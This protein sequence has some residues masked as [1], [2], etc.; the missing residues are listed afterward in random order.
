MR[1]NAMKL[2]ILEAS[3]REITEATGIDRVSIIHLFKRCLLIHPDGRI[4]GFRALLL[5]TRIMP[6]RRSAPAAVTTATSKSGACA[7]GNLLSR[8][9]DIERELQDYV[10]KRARRKHGNLSGNRYVHESRIPIKSLHKRFI[11]ACRKHNLETMGQY[12]ST[13]KKLAYE[14]L[15]QYVH[16][17]MEQNWDGGAKARLGVDAAKVL[18]TGDGTD[19]PVFMPFER[20]ECDAHLIDAIFCI[21]IPSLSDELIPQIVQRL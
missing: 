2:L 18:R 19:R 15:S 4:Y 8:F 7:F 16:K 5:R 10:L 12:P 11:E 1:K 6:Y 9:P 3:R 17:L 21:L 14:A 20:V 13:T